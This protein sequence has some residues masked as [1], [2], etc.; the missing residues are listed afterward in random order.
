MALTL[1]TPQK[2]TDE[3]GW[4]VESWSQR[5]WESF[6]VHDVYV[7]DNHSLSRPVYTLRGLHFQTPPHAQAKLVRCVRGRLL[8]VCVDL[9]QHSPTYGKWLSAEL[10]AEN[11]RQL[12]IPAGFAHGFLTLEAD[13]ELV[14]KVSDYYARECDSGLI[15]NDNDLG[16][17]WPLNGHAPVL[18]VKDQRL[19]RLS[20]FNS[21]FT[22]DGQPMSLREVIYER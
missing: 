13:T 15:W 3:R 21:P 11:G 9:R 10:S 16:I 17:H 5:V 18:S 12:H 20:E 6:G 8:D 7:Q 19:M 2:F 22:Y 4:F 14:Y 1:F